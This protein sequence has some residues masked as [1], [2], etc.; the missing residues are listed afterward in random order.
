MLRPGHRQFPFIINTFLDGRKFNNWLRL[1]ALSPCPEMLDHFLPAVYPLHLDPSFHEGLLVHS[2][3]LLFSTGDRCLPHILLSMWEISSGKLFGFLICFCVITFMLSCNPFQ[4]VISYFPCME[5]EKL[6]RSRPL[7]ILTT[8]SPVTKST[9]Y[10]MVC[11]NIG[12]LDP[13]MLLSNWLCEQA[14][15]MA[16]T[17]YQRVQIMLWKIAGIKMTANEGL[18]APKNCLTIL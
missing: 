18:R 7:Y 12:I 6:P 10:R 14:A 13:S 4:A 1:H 16:C 8:K 9:S 15:R 11:R 17:T 2:T 3:G 5:H